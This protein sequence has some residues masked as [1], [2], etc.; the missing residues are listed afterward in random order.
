MFYEG[1]TSGCLELLL[2]EVHLYTR[3]W[4]GALAPCSP[5]VEAKSN[6]LTFSIL[7]FNFLFQKY[8]L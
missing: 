7:G 2:Q 3:V 4:P 6:F 5:G 1:I 8:V